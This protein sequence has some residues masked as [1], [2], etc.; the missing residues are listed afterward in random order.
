MCS[1]VLPCVFISWVHIHVFVSGIDWCFININKPLD[2]VRVVERG[3]QLERCCSSVA[4]SIFDLCTAG[5][6]RIDD[7]GS[8]TLTSFM[9]SSP[10]QKSCYID[11][12]NSVLMTSPI[13]RQ[14]KRVTEWPKFVTHTRKLSLNNWCAKHMSN[15]MLFA[16]TSRISCALVA[17]YIKSRPLTNNLHNVTAVYMCALIMQTRRHDWLRLRSKLELKFYRLTIH[18]AGARA[19]RTL[20]VYASFSEWWI[21]TTTQ[22]SIDFVHQC[23]MPT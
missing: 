5:H 2:A 20:A 17:A 22:G 11:V 13:D 9:K 4:V 23:T 10:V 3:H 16:Y 1:A 21:S 6:G 7:A 8:M 18:T 19:D 14:F 15:C 12:G